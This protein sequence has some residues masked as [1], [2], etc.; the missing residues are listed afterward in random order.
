MKLDA[1][2]MSNRVF[3]DQTL[4][5]R[6]R[7]EDAVAHK[8]FNDG[9]SVLV[10]L[11]DGMGGHQGGEVAARTS[12]DAFISAFFTDFISLKTPYRLF[13]ALTRANKELEALIRKNTELEGMGSTL[14]G[15]SFSSMGLSWISVGDSLLLRVRGRIMHRL[16]EDH[17]M[18]PV[19]DEAVKNGTL[20]REQAVSNKDRNALRSAVTGATIDLVDIPDRPEP[21]QKGDVVLL[22]SDGLLTLSTDEIIRVVRAHKANGA[23][24]IVGAL[25][26][27][28]DAKKKRRQDNTTIAAIV[29]DRSSTRIPVT[30][31][32]Q[33]SFRVSRFVGLAFVILTAFAAGVGSSLLKPVSD[34]VQ[35]IATELVS[36]KK[37]SVQGDDRESL[38]AETIDISGAP[39]REDVPAENHSA[40]PSSKTSRFGEITLEGSTTKG[41]P[42]KF[43]ES[44]SDNEQKTEEVSLR[45]APQ[46]GAEPSQGNG[47]STVVAPQS[48][49]VRADVKYPK[50][51]RS[52]K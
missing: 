21:V 49:E 26:K 46:R 52:E 50:M 37:V 31:S 2:R 35:F 3:A 47:S 19:L 5:E 34:F 22:A 11:A 29:V 48:S 43:E 30:N 27:A 40:P 6:D 10:V 15:V 12:V 39:T 16:N 13:G 17:S 42:Q 24:A 28:V 1:E 38:G 20:T 14:L 32:P 41:T 33:L 44:S 4:G 45:D 23:P 51:P 25:L 18:A 8:S 7:Q 36:E 9:D